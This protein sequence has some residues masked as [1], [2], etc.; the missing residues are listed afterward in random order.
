MGFVSDAL[1][2][3]G[4]DAAEEAADAQVYSNQLAINEMRRQYDETVNRLAPFVDVGSNQ[5][6]ALGAASTVSGLDDRLAQILNSDTFG[7]L[8]DARKREVGNQLSQTGLMRSGAGLR[9][10]AGIP[11]ELALALENMLYG[12]TSNLVG[13]SQNA[14]AGLGSLG[15]DNSQGISSLLQDQGQ[16]VGQGILQGQQANAQAGSNLINAGL[17]AASIFFSDE[18]L[19]DNM[20]PIGKLA[21]LTLYEWDWKPGITPIVGKMNIGFSAQEVEQA[22]PD[23]VFEIAGRKAIA[24]PRLIEKLQDQLQEAA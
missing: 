19:K 21:G 9:A 22:H 3:G 24:Y 5:V 11:T 8:Y 16:A 14:A 7:A 4:D 15:S 1:G 20:E 23:C 18:R 6:D 12:R 13:S 17:T 10:A 2:K